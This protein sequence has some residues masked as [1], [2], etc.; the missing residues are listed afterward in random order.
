LIKA[1]IGGI[2]T[3]FIAWLSTKGNVLPG[4]VPLFPTLTL[5]ALY[6][7]GA[8][9][10][11]QGFQETCLATFKTV[12]AYLVFVIVC[13]LSIK[14]VGYRAALLLG[15]A[16]WSAAALIV[17]LAPKALQRFGGVT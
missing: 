17:F 14:R 8:K 10:D 5:I 16:G 2:M 9:G 11:A 7:V 12:P 6:I 13:Y 1:V 4:I 3:A 15:L